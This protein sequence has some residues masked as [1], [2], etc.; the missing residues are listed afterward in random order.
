MTTKTR[1]GRDLARGVTIAIVVALV[2]AVALWWVMVDANQRRYTAMFT[3]TVGL[4]EDN[5]VRVLGVKV[6]HVDKVEPE[7]DLVRVEM[8]VDR[9]VKIPASADAVIVAPSLVSDRYVQFT[10]AYV[11][12]AV[13]AE[14]TVLPRERTQTP[15]EVDDLYASL[16]RVSTTLGP[17]GA[18]K[19]GA[20][21]D[22]LK[23]LAKNAKGNGKALNDTITQL[24]KFAGTLSGSDK[25]LFATVDNLQRFTT[26][27]ANSDDQVNQFSE[28]AAQVTG[29]LADER[30]DLGAAVQQLG[31]ALGEVQQF[32]DHNRARLKSNVDK[33]A[34]VTQVLVDQRASL[35]E[36]LDTA[37]VALSNII[38]SYNGSSG[39]LDA[40]ADI[41]ELSEPPIVLLCGLLRQETPSKLPQTLADTCDQLAPVVK[42]LVP[43][44]SP[45]AVLTALQSGKL[46]PLPVPLSNLYGTES[47]GGGK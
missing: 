43:L 19:N 29:F 11:G 10:P 33:L 35:A 39:T 45:A 16:N 15:L 30:G 18:N 26:T 8:L 46:P 21:S 23:T 47:K 42:G 4:Y 9:S 12:G 2:V 3:G 37:P 44:P 17:N 5:D 32:I 7:G 24:S 27:L 13:M 6:G 28:Q 14:G 1:L 22:L 31:V 20:L 38:N 41:N 25:D 36:V 40:R 34:S